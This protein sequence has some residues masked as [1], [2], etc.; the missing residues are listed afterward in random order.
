MNTK[1]LDILEYDKIIENLNKYC[2]TYIAKQK[3]LDLRP[4]FE[5]D[6][7]KNLL[8][9]TD[10][11][12]NLI[13]RKSS[14]PLAE[15]PNI[16]LWLKQLDSFST[17]S[18]KALL[19]TA[20]F[21]KI[22][23]EVKEYFYSDEELEFSKYP[24][25]SEY[26]SNL[27]TNKNIEEKILNIILDENTVSDNASNKLF[28]IRKQIKKIEQ[29]IRD[30]LNN[31][32]HSSTY[33]KYIMEPIITIRNDRFVIPVKEEYKN[34]IKGFIHDISSSGSSVFIEPINIF[35]MNNQISNLKVEEE[36]EIEKILQELSSM[37][38]EHTDLLKVN[39]EMIGT[40]D[41]IF[42]KANY[43]L[44]LDGIFPKINQEKYIN[45]IKV[46][47][48]LIN[49]DHVVPIDISL[50]KDYS[51][52]VITGPNTGG[53]TVCLKTVGLNLLMA[54]SGIFI[55]CNENSSIYV[56][57]N[58][59]ADI[60]DEQSIQESLS[61]F[62]SHISNIVEIINT[63]STNSLIL[64][65]ELGSGTDP[66]EGANLAISILQYFY[67]VGLLVI[68]TTHYQELKNHCLMTDGFENA[69][70]E[71]DIEKLQP[72]YKLLI[73]IPGKSNAFAI[74]KKLGLKQE[75]LD[76]ANSLMK[77]EDISIEEL[78]KSI[79]DDK[80]AIENEKVEIEKNANQIESLRKS[81]EQKNSN[82]ETHEKEI[83]EK[84]KIE[85]R[86]L[87]LSAK[88]E[89]NMIIKEINKIEKDYKNQINN[90]NNNDLNRANYLRNQLNSK[91][92]DIEKVGDTSNTLN[93]EILKT[94]NSKDRMKNNK[95][96]SNSN[97]DKKNMNS[98]NKNQYSNVSFI[99]NDQYKSKNISSEINVIGLN[100]DEAIFLIDKYL[101]DCAI[102]KLSPI[103]I[104]HG[105]GTGKLRQGIHAFLK[106]NSHVKSFRIGTFGEGEMGVTVVELK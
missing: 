60:G 5:L 10:E 58:I 62:S 101:D 38:Y 90:F 70:C 11:A 46:R 6:T 99:K 33:S 79:Y 83:L 43:S 104:V 50:G 57:D 94:L 103:R 13:V 19:E 25:L 64:L 59:F 3:L 29:E 15:I 55:P 54:Y 61:T 48:P 21:L 9:Q 86:N 39:L 72:T 37:L 92:Q 66:I 63:A 81:L 31:F 85:A 7:V 102:A 71:F 41:L 105:K 4:S 73:G 67:K 95:L 16:N 44:Q 97:N 27:Y 1:Y 78:M 23:R 51:S 35:E 69:S 76:N 8:T 88:S 36:I 14:I 91:L 75:I 17:L 52:L 80:I 82:V 98:Y 53:K 49:K 40:L 26:F 68:S 12:V 56:F 34:N 45:L 96:S 20:N 74:S 106:T 22:V 65:D 32:I 100:V 87:I 2:K 30:K 24:I 89:V 18:L 28:S 93:L 42:A 47:H 77:N 84:A